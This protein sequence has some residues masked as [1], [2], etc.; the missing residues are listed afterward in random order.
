MTPSRSGQERSRSRG[1]LMFD[2]ARRN[3][4]IERLQERIRDMD[5]VIKPRIKGDSAREANW[6]EWN[7]QIMH[8]IRQIQNR[9]RQVYWLRLTTVIS[10]I[11][12]PSLVGLNLSGTGGVVVRWITFALSLIAAVSTAFI[13]LFGLGGRWLMYDDLKD[14]LLKIGWDL[15][16]STTTGFDKD[17]E[18]FIKA[19]AK[20]MADYNAIYK[21]VVI[22]AAQAAPRDI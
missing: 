12:V 5:G 10:A 3:H 18:K 7:D 2:H 22:G 17:W 19:M 11:T 21:K 1:F 4:H 6:R 16:N 9:K 15:V 20:A 14:D 13:A 8:A